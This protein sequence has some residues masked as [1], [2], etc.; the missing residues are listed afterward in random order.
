MVMKTLAVPISAGSA[1]FRAVS[2]QPGDEAVDFVWWD[3]AS[4]DRSDDVL[5][6]LQPESGRGRKAHIVEGDQ[7]V[8]LAAEPALD[9]ALAGY[10]VGEAVVGSGEDEC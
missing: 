6:R 1:E 10:G 3:A 7:A 8:I 2:I 4:W 5:L 9:L